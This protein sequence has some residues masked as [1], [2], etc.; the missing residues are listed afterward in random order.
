MTLIG[1]VFMG[2][3]LVSLTIQ[4]VMLILLIEK[5]STQSTIERLTYNGLLRT[6]VCRVIAAI[7]YVGVGIATLTLPPGWE[8]FVLMVF[9]VVQVLWWINAGADVFLRRYIEKSNRVSGEYNG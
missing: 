9:I 6:S 8:I 2:V 7:L 3:A 5:L 1:V 4:T